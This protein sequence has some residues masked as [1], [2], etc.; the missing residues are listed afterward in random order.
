MR[1]QI[2]QN[3]LQDAAAVSATSPASLLLL[4][5]CQQLTLVLFQRQATR[6]R[7]KRLAEVVANTDELARRRDRL[8]AQIQELQA[9]LDAVTRA[10]AAE[11]EKVSVVVVFYCQPL[12]A[13]KWLLLWLCSASGVGGCTSRSRGE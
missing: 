4:L 12:G 1:K 3:E 6:D 13:N 10:R 9:Q 2:L 7:N 8:S 11:E 5:P